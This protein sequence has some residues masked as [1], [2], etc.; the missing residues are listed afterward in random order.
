MT[1]LC[2]PENEG[3]KVASNVG[4]A[5]TGELGHGQINPLVG[6]EVVMRVNHGAGGALELVK[7]ASRRLRW[8]PS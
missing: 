6:T 4:L 3:D 2:I 8:H 5:N 7:D 1:L